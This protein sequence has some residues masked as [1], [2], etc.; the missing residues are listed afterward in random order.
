VASRFTVTDCVLVPPADV[1]V[2]VNVTADVSAVTLLVS[3]PSLL[4]TGDAPALTVHET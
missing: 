2:Q 1:A 3:H 4:E